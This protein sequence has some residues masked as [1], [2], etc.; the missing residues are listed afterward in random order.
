MANDPSGATYDSGVYPQGW[1][2]IVFKGLSARSDFAFR[3]FTL[4]TFDNERRYQSYIFTLGRMLGLP[5]NSNKQSWMYPYYE[6]GVKKE[7]S[8]EELSFLQNIASQCSTGDVVESTNAPNITAEGTVGFSVNFKFSKDFKLKKAGII[9]SE[10]PEIGR[11]H[12]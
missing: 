8:Q 11:A 4:K 1:N 7:F 2:E 6:A 10:N 3:A 9:I 5:E 12:V